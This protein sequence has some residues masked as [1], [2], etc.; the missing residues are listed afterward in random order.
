[1][2]RIL[3]LPTHIIRCQYIGIGGNS[4]PEKASEAQALASLENLQNA[5]QST[6][7]TRIIP[8]VDYNAHIASQHNSSVAAAAL[9]TTSLNHNLLLRPADCIPLILY[10]EK[11][12]K[13]ILALIH[14]GRR[15]LDQDIIR[16]TL[17]LIYKEYDLQPE[18]L[19][20][21]LGPSIK[22]QSYILPRSVLDGF[23]HPNWPQFVASKSKTTVSI[24]INGFAESELMRIGLLRSN[25]YIST[26]DTS[27]NPRYYSHYASWH[28]AKKKP[29]L[30]GF[31]VAII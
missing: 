4:F 27:T 29:G 18:G 13:P 21:Y 19:S 8:G 1:M 16:K 24:D 12:H 3:I 25:I 26:I 6:T 28:L 2:K 9:V 7:S 20:A 11:N 30:N 31:V 22:R 15:E 5:Y 23:S 14:G 10:G 17:D